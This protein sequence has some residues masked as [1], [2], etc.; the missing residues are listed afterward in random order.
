ARGRG[1]TK[2]SDQSSPGCASR[3][4]ARLP[5]RQPLS[6]SPLTKAL[7]NSQRSETIDS[8]MASPQSCSRLPRRMKLSSLLSAEIVGR[9]NGGLDPSGSGD[10]ARSLTV[11]TFRSVRACIC[12]EKG[13]PTEV[14]ICGIL[15]KG[16]LCGL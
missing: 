2:P 16:L 12:I 1:C 11:I 14:E 9:L 13:I 8:Y 5:P 4:L 15:K 6:T 7:E 3:S 10:M